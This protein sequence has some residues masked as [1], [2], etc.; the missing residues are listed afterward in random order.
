MTET[1]DAKGDALLPSSTSNGQHPA[2]SLP[3]DPIEPA[4]INGLS[5]AAAGDGADSYYFDSSNYRCC[6]GLFHAKVCTFV[7]CTWFLHEIVLGTIYLLSRLGSTDADSAQHHLPL[8]LLCRFIQI[9]TV[10]LLY[11]ALWRHR[12]YLLLPFAAVQ[13]TVGTFSDLATLLLLVGQM[14]RSVGGGENMPFGDGVWSFLHW[15]LPAML[16]LAVVAGLMYALY[17]CYVFLQARQ[18]HDE[19][20]VMEKSQVGLI[21]A[22]QSR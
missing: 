7:L 22:H 18:A 4:R 14:E 3:A 21:L 19:K 15:L 17:R 10:A 6:F 1:E 5:G 9:P 2:S 13:C 12:A 11:I 20:R 16:Y 8:L